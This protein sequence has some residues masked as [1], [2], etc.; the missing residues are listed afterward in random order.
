MT[1]DGA[2]GAILARNSIDYLVTQLV[3]FDY[4]VT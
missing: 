3:T 4:P 2:L 1:M